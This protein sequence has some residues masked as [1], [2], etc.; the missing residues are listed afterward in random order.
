MTQLFGR[1]T[2]VGGVKI[3]GQRFEAIFVLTHAI[4]RT[5][6]VERSCSMAPKYHPTPVSGSHPLG[7][8]EGADI[9]TL[10]PTSNKIV[11]VVVSSN[12]V[13]LV[14]RVKA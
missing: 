5:A 3:E 6:R 8:R 11:P 9:A 14:A 12:E 2:A 7:A 10:G 13:K 4:C 1:S